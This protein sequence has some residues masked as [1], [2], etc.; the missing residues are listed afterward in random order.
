MNAIN[1][2]SKWSLVISSTVFRFAVFGTLREQG[3]SFSIDKRL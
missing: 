1:E 2:I 3:P